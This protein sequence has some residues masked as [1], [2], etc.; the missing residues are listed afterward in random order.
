MNM[1]KQLKSYKSD[2][3]VKKG[4]CFQLVTLGEKLAEV[5]QTQI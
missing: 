1:Y 4:Y 3:R 5:Y 2:S